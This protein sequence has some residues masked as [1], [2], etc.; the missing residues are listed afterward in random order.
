MA[1]PLTVQVR[2]G[3][4]GKEVTLEGEL[5]WT[6]LTLKEKLEEASRIPV[7]RQILVSGSRQLRNGERLVDVPTTEAKESLI[8]LTLVQMDVPAGFTKERL[9]YTWQAYLNFSD[10]Y[11]ESVDRSVLGK[12]LRF[13]GIYTSETQL[14]E[15][16]GTESSFSF[17][18]VLRLMVEWKQRYAQST[19]LKV[20]QRAYFVRLLE[21]LDPDNTGLVSR[22][23][24][25]QALHQWKVPFGTSVFLSKR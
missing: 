18:D 11:G 10:A 13:V 12:V 3:L 7:C 24:F 19:P 5:S 15:L 16:C 17:R 4:C 21:N 23:T 6:V 22:A 9:D 2:L 25:S 1:E 20:L 14:D 8:P